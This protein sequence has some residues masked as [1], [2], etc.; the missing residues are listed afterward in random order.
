MFL[1]ITKN[2]MEMANLFVVSGFIQFDQCLV[3]KHFHDWKM[4]SESRLCAT[5]VFMQHKVSN[6]K[7]TAHTAFQAFL[8]LLETWLLFS[9]GLFGIQLLAN[10]WLNII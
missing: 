4:K 5:L 7:T 3:S 10:I 6:R 8:R 1:A 2:K 9:V